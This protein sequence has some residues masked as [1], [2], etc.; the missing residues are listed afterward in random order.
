MSPHV[1]TAVVV[2]ACAVLGLA[3][4]DLALGVTVLNLV[5]TR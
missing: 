5:L 2:F 3:I 4:A 1:V